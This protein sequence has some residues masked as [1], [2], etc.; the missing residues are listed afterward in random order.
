MEEKVVEDLIKYFKN[1]FG[2]LVVTIGKKHTFLC[3]NINIRGDQK[4]EIQMKN[5]LLEAIEEFG[6]NIDEK[7][8][9]P[10]SIHLFLVK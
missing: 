6:E 4:F 1:H 7:V 5:Q 9:T 3:V 2:Q 10:A 8:T